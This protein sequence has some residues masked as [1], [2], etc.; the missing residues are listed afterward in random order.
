[1]TYNKQTGVENIPPY[2]ATNVCG[3]ICRWTDAGSKPE[4]CFFC[5]G[6]WIPVEDLEIGSVL[7]D[8]K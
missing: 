7:S 3:G 5:S 4:H 8:K 2:D 6:E 1:L